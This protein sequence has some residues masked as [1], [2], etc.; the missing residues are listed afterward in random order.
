MQLSAMS[1]KP[2]KLMI[3]RHL[4]SQVGLLEKA[5]DMYARA[6]DIQSAKLGPE[7]PDVASTMN[8][9]AGLLKVMG[10]FG[11]AESVYRTVCPACPA[12][13]MVVRILPFA[14]NQV[15]HRQAQQAEQAELVGRKLNTLPYLGEA[16]I[17]IKQVLA[18]RERE[19]G[20]DH[21]EVAASLNNLAVLLKTT[22]ANEEAETLLQRSI[23]IKE[24]ALGPKHPQVLL[25]SLHPVVPCGPTKLMT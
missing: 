19:L 20:P 8:H 13:Q 15:H 22:G 2:V 4:L 12:S 23:C 25:R 5:Q 14:G 18:M 16:S 3:S 24:A 11:D 17:A 1:L 9:T 7:H 10:K 21:L 6:Y